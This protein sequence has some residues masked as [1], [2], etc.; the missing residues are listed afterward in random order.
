MGII[1][2]LKQMIIHLSPYSEAWPTRFETMKQT[3]MRL[4]KG[5]AQAIE[6]VGSTAVRGLMAK[7]VI[8]I[9]LALS[10]FHSFPYYEEKLQPM[11]FK[12]D[13][14]GM[15]ERY[16]FSKYTSEGV[17][18]HNLH[19]LPWNEHFMLRNE[20]LFRDYLRKAPDLVV[21][22]NNLKKHLASIPLATLEDYTRAKTGFIQQVVDRACLERGLPEQNVWTMEIEE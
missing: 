3:L 9:F 5:D 18:T 8:D 7:P 17:W 19:V 22:Y 6:H 15:S 1:T 20:I 4:F 11:G 2:L 10:P 12:Y 14:T 21:E 13:H 16:L